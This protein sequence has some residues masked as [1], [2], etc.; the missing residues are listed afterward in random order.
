MPEMTTEEKDLEDFDRD[1]KLRHP[2][3]DLFDETS[4]WMYDSEQIGWLT[5]RRQ[6]REE[7]RAI[8]QGLISGDP[9][10]ETI[11]R[12]WQLVEGK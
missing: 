1:F 9:R 4:R 11:N 12:L 7:L 5:S 2:G 3:Y 10:E 6:L 8:L